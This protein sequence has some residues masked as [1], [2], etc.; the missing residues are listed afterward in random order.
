MFSRKILGAADAHDAGLRIEPEE[1][2]R[3]SYVEVQRFERSRRQV[4]DESRYS[5]LDDL[6]HVPLKH[7]QMPIRFKKLSGVERLKYLFQERLET[8]RKKKVE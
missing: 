7:I 5:T 4:D 2:R 1:E 6:L 8:S 3:E